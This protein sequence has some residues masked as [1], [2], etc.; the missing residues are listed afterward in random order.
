[1]KYIKLTRGKSVKVD[2]A[3]YES[4]NQF[5]W[6]CSSRDYA[7][8]SVCEDGKRRMIYMHRLLLNTPSNLE[9]DHMNGDRLDNQRANLRVCTASQNQQNRHKLSTNTSG[10]RGVTWHKK[11]QKWQAQI[12]L[13]RRTVYLGLFDELEVARDAYAA[14]AHSAFG[15]FTR[16]AV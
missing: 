2:N 13:N 15:A 16:K 4:L 8:R 3:D 10:V 7:A 6:H 14:V 5:R 9:T 1:M 11:T 12:G